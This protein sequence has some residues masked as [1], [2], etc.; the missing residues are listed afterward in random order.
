MNASDWTIWDMYHPGLAFSLGLKMDF[1]GAPTR[2]SEQRRLIM[3]ARML[4]NY[5]CV[6]RV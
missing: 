2:G 1:A 4:N 6:S 3:N 5:W